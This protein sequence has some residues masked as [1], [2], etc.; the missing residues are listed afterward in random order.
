MR[1]VAATLQLLDLEAASVFELARELKVAPPPGWPPEYNGP[2]TR[3]WV[4]Q[5]M[6]SHPN[7]SAWYSSYVVA[8][9]AGSETLV[10]I[11]GF[12]GAPDESA[13][14]EIGYSIVPEFQRRGLATGAVALIC[15]RAASGGAKMVTAETLPTLT[16][17]QKVL[18]NS[19]FEHFETYQDAEVGEIWR[20][21]RLA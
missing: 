7:A 16:A 2:E 11:C 5:E 14:V 1:L 9:V 17:S 12:K 19:G 15:V 13:T 4:R 8:F 10:G 21:R 20:Y 6:R 18:L 3:Q